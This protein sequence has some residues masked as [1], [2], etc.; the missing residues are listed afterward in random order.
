M[1]TEQSRTRY[2]NM[3]IEAVVNADRSAIIKARCGRC[4]RDLVT[5]NEAIHL[6]EQ[7]LC[8]YQDIQEPD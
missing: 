5:V 8:G 7:R 3:V 1:L 2:P 6:H 4:L